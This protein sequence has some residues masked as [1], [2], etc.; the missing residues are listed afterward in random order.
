MSTVYNKCIIE[1]HFK[2]VLLA[3]DFQTFKGLVMFKKRHPETTR[4]LCPVPGDF[5]WWVHSVMAI[6][7]IWWDVIFMRLHDED[8]FGLNTVIEKWDSV[9]KFDKYRFFHETIICAA[10]QYL[11]EVVPDFALTSP[12]RL[13]DLCKA[14]EGPSLSVRESVLEEVVCTRL[15]LNNFGKRC[16]RLGAL[17][18]RV[19]S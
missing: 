9:E 1:L 14:N 8:E 15:C 16:A 10:L 17:P 6:H 12:H 19:R 13:E 2:V 11:H 3:G 4:W 5:H 18:S 7:E